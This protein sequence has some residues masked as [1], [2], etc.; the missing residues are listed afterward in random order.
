MTNK[1]HWGTHFLDSTL[2]DLHRADYIQLGFGVLLPTFVENIYS[3]HYVCQHWDYSKYITE[4][5]KDLSRISV[6]FLLK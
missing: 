6:V 1:I 5:A 2:I 3:K 4:E